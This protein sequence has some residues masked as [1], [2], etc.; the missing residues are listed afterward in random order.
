M[1]KIVNL[2]NH[3]VLIYPYNEHQVV[4]INIHLFILKIFILFSHVIYGLFDLI[5]LKLL[6]YLDD[7]V[8][9]VTNNS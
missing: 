2:I 5:F 7:R 8:Y 3:E 6:G 4:I 1:L 9:T